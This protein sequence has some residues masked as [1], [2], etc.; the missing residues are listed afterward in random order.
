M[1]FNKIA[2]VLLICINILFAQT[3][4]QIN[5]NFKDLKINDLIKITS[6][7]IGKNILLTYKIKGTVDFVSNK[8]VYKDD[9]INILMYVLEEKGYTILDND[10]ILR[11]VRINNA[12]KYNA[13]V[14]SGV[15][16]VKTSGMITEVFVVQY[17]NVDYISSKIRHL[18]SKSAKL[19]TDKSSNS[20]VLTGFLSNIKTVKKL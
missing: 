13:P 16:K 9:I 8:P 5:I 15:T 3:K 17:S 1:R 11:I 14:Y 10:G 4:E 19:V 7:I 6:K 18:I 2:L 20:I 12:S